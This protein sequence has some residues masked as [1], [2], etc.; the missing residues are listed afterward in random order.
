MQRLS[1][2]SNISIR[3][4]AAS[5]RRC[6]FASLHGADASD[7]ILTS[8]EPSCYHLGLCMSVNRLAKMRR[9]TIHHLRVQGEEKVTNISV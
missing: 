1:G 3:T 4:G 5:R 6:L 8:D 2:S 9:N 7:N